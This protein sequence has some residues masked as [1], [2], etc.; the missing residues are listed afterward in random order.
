MIH[1]KKDDGVTLVIAILIITAVALVVG[2]LL[3]QGDGS[4]RATL[5]VR[6]VADS[7][8]SA[9]GAAQIAINNMVKGSGFSSNPNESAF[10][11]GTDG[12]GCFGNLVG[13]GATDNMSLSSSFYK[14]YG[15]GG[16]NSAYVE[17][18]PESGTGAQGSPVPISSSNKPGYAI[19]TLGGDLATNDPLKVHGGV[20]SNAAI[21]GSVSLDAGDAWANGACTNT[22]V[23]ATGTKHCNTGQTLAD[24]NY[25]NELGGVVPALQTPP[26]T[27]TSGVAVFLPGYYDD[28]AALSTATSLCSVAWFKPGTYY[29]DFHNNSCG[30]YCPTSLFGT[31]GDTWTIGGGTVVGGTPIDASGNVLSLPPT[32]PTMPGS[33]QSPITSTTAQGVQFVFGNDSRMYIDQNSH[34]ELCG[35]YHANRPPIV[36]YG[37]KTGSTP[38]TTSSAGLA[39]TG[40]TSTTTSNASW[41]SSLTTANLA[42]GGS[43][44]TWT[45]TAA[46][47]QSTTVTATGFGASIPS[48]AVL[49]AATVHIVHQDAEN[50]ATSNGSA[51][52][53][54][55]TAVSAAHTITA[56]AASAAGLVSEDW[57]L[58]GTDLSNL[59]KQIHTSGFSSATVAYTA[60]ASKNSATAKLDSITLDLTYYLPVLRGESGTAVATGTT[61]PLVSMKNGNN[62]ILMYWQGTTY[63]PLDYVHIELGNF[64]S[65][66]A[67][68]GIVAR[69]LL[70]DIT[71]GNPLYTGPIFEVPDNSPGY[72]YNSTV[73]DLTVHLC[74]GASTCTSSGA[75]ALKARVQLYDPSGSPVA[76]Q[77]AVNILGWS[78]Q[79]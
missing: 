54:V 45:T 73:V 8:Y 18:T 60:K 71:N 66:V 17:C 13:L 46:S 35:T 10:N 61:T 72:G 15:N 32:S 29:F 79:R 76:G 49:T 20:Y 3:T 77:R 4:L 12:A 7:S 68:F 33:C 24:P 30:G 57:A 1:R 58:S 38:S 37:L 11:N 42:A 50:K 75:V 36:I 48:G 14:A 9:E 64:A 22:T 44:A 63:V 59:Q 5:A 52:L 23:A 39:V 65:E 62:K 55:G 69:Q 70:F 67:K 21:T 78:E 34:I 27:C 56:T 26:T 16:G 47:A 43:V 25:Q 6:N 40:V 41:G 31:A 51:T 53:T 2:V 28:A 19:I 74:P